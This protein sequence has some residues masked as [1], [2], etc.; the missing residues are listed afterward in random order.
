M[1]KI[2]EGLKYQGVIICPCNC[3]KR[4]KGYTYYIHAKNTTEVNCSHYW[5]LESAKADAKFN[6][7]N[8]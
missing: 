8:R 1:G 5:T 3:A 6:K 7:E 4:E 2:K